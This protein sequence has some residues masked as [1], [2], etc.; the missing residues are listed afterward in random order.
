MAAHPGVRSHVRAAAV[1]VPVGVL[2][3]AEVTVL[4]IVADAPEAA[5]EAAVDAMAAAV[6]GTA[7]VQDVWDVPA[8]AGMGAKETVMEIAREELTVNAMAVPEHVPLAAAAVRDAMAV[9]DAGTGVPEPVRIRVRADAVT[10]RVAAVPAVPAATAVQAVAVA[11]AGTAIRAVRMPVLLSVRLRPAGVAAVPVLRDVPGAA[12]IPVR[13][14]A[15]LDARIAVRP[16]AHRP[17]IL[18]ARTSALAVRSN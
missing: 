1:L 8:A 2:A 10:V 14:I 4:E 15:R 9:R 5:E 17:A 18:P 6:V 16:H 11:A 13:R 12:G 7:V 3:A